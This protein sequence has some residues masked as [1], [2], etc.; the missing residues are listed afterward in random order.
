MK[1]D[2]KEHLLLIAF[3]LFVLLVMATA[4]YAAVILIPQKAARDF[5]VPDPGLERAVCHQPGGQP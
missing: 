2:K 5:G 1:R 4:Y 3:L